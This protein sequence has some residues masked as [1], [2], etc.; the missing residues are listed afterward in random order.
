MLRPRM[1]PG[2]VAVFVLATLTKA[3]EP[4]AI[5]HSRARGEGQLPNTFPYSFGWAVVVIEMIKLGAPAPPSSHAPP[6]PPIDCF[7]SAERGESLTD[8]GAPVVAC[9]VG[10]AV[11]LRGLSSSDRAAATALDTTQFGRLGIPGLL[12]ALTN[13]GMFAALARVRICRSL[14]RTTAVYVAIIDY[15]QW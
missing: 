14:R 2:L 7:T 1:P 8:P 12:L 6:L 5:S 9:G 4:L 13:W 10:L 15:H 11:Q 3:L